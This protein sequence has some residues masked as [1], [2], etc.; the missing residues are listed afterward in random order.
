MTLQTNRE[1]RQAA[2]SGTRML[3]MEECFDALVGALIASGAMPENAAAVMLDH[4]A[5][6]FLD[7][8]SGR[9]ESVWQIDPIELR[10]QADRLKNRAAPR[11]VRA[12]LV[13]APGL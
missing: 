8:A 6:R 2:I 7:H 5:E 10:C 4:L 12:E 9:A 1:G 3:V 13:A 11:S